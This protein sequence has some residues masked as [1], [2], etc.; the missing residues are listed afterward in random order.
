[1]TPLR[2]LLAR[3]AAELP[4]ADGTPDPLLDGSLAP[5]ARRTSPQ[6]ARHGSS[7]L[8]T[9]AQGGSPPVE[10]DFQALQPVVQQL[11]TGQENPVEDPATAG[12]RPTPASDGPDAVPFD[13]LR[14]A[15]ESRVDQLERDWT[16]ALEQLAEL[17]RRGFAT[18]AEQV[19]LADRLRD[20][21]NAH[22]LR[23]RL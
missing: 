13:A 6:Q 16:Q 4:A 21:E 14:L 17:F 5:L 12:E 3:L 15:L 7:S 20:L 19:A 10:R 2:E 11:A 18:K 22:V 1:M 23:G 8:P 9:G